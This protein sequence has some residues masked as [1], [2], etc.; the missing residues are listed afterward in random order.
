MQ[1]LQTHQL[2]YWGSLREH[3]RSA[4]VCSEVPVSSCLRAIQREHG[5]IQIGPAQCYYGQ[6]HCRV[7]LIH[8]GTAM[9]LFFLY[10]H[11]YVP[12]NNLIHTTAVRLVMEYTFLSIVSLLERPETGKFS[13]MEYASAC[14]FLHYII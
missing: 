14:S 3:L 4:C 1:N 12:H 11:R 10:I 7:A 2:H 8:R 13:L 6:S 5:H 9:S